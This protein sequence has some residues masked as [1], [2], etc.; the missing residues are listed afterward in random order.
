MAE[1]IDRNSCS[2]C[3]RSKEDVPLLI[4]GLQGNICTDCLGHGQELIQ[5]QIAHEKSLNPTASEA[6]VL[7]MKPSDIM[8]HLN[9]FI[10]GQDKAKKVMSV[11]VY[12]HYKRINQ[13]TSDEMD[14]I[15]IEKSNIMMVGETGTG[16]TLIAKTIAKLLKVPF[17]IVDATTLT[18]AGYVGEDVESALSR[19]LQDADGDVEKA[20]KGI[21]FVDEIDKIGRK[22]ENPSITR[23]VAGEGVQQSL[24]KL[25]EG[26]IVNVPPNGGRKH[27][28]QKGI[29]VD[30]KDIL[31]ICGG[32]FEGIQKVIAKRLNTDTVGFKTTE[33]DEKSKS[34]NFLSQIIP[35]DLRSFGLIPEMIGRIPVLTH[36]NPLDK[37][38]L[39][40]ILTVPNNSVIKQYTE[41]FNIDG[42]E[43]T[44]EED[45]LDFI[46]DKALEYKL[47]ARG[48]RSI[49][50]TIMTDIMY[51]AP[52]L[53]SKEINI[54]KQYAET[55]F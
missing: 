4:T 26:S 37:T 30:T 47:G 21:V 53:N 55:Y 28:D 41:L 23:D 44:F 49:C 46:V 50:E 36:L 6:L 15:D 29:A 40:Q 9:K 24:L 7:D 52:D 10:V 39:R 3:G 17:A 12:N 18:Q 2:F 5:T 54:T 38:I 11:A 42:V 22:S 13:V 31:F 51:D 20:Q 35:N 32:A 14:A 43:L 48:L 1:K 25:L 33:S 16:K 45:T 34:N 8:A 27:P 19:L